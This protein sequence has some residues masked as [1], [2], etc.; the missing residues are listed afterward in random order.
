MQPTQKY[1]PAV[2]YLLAAA[3]VLGLGIDAA[4]GLTGKDE[5]LLGLRIPLEMMQGD[6]WWVPFIDGVPRLKKPPMLYWLG[7]GSFEI[8]GPS[9]LAARA[10]T[11]AFALLLLGCTAWLG[12]YLT[13]RWQTG[14]LAAA[15]L[16]GM[17]GMASESRRLM[18]DV[19]VAA[20]SVTALC[21]YLSWLDRPRITALLGTAACLCAALLTKGPIAFVA[22]GGGLLALWATRRETL[23]ALRQRWW[24]HLVMLGLALALPVFWYLQVRALYGAELAQAAQDEMEA[25]Q[26]GL[27]ADALIGII[28]I[29]L[30]WP[31]VAFAGLWS[32]RREANTRFA[33]VWLLA[34]LVPFFFIRSFDRYLIG[35]LP[36]LALLAAFALKA[37]KDALWAKRLGSLLMA[38]PA[39]ILALL[40]W[41]WQL[42]GWCLLSLVWLGFVF[43]W[44]RRASNAV[45]LA[46]TAAL[47]WA[48]GWGVAFPALGVN[49]VPPA[50]IELAHDKS[51]ILFDGPQ[52]A[53]LPILEKRP[54]RQ[55]SQ[56]AL[57]IEAGTLMMVRAEDRAALDAQLAA[58]NLKA[59]LRL[60]YQSLTSAGSGIRFAK[61]G[62]TAGDWRRAWD[63][64]SPAPL[65]STV[66]AL[67]VLP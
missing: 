36:A 40:L 5:Y 27:S 25:R 53:L 60:E 14:L 31:F 37:G 15:V 3:V 24:A 65:M 30:P 49:S 32:L 56:L 7:R 58:L 12:R 2:F 46:A 18:L 23:L 38:L 41:R 4:T 17:S 52:P 42:G 35:S 47:L 6:H 44:W 39:A 57:P 11:V 22:C 55:T 43:V 34:T 45:S 29:A 63:E 1:L 51:V 66:Q 59:T 19:P 13:G 64:R 50:V 10:I 26:I 28:T 48:I 61:S 16:L 33:A 62:A 67:E 8:F 9:L 20:L 21:C 54:L